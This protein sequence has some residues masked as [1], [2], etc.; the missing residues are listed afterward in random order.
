MWGASKMHAP[1]D[2]T[3]GDWGLMVF[4]L[5]GE[6]NDQVLDKAN[7]VLSTLVFQYLVVDRAPAIFCVYKGTTEGRNIEAWAVWGPPQQ[8]AK[9]YSLALMKHLMHK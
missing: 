3:A 1:Y 5:T 2:G 8:N 6:N 9:G 4:S 7:K